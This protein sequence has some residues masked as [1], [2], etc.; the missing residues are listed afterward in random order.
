MT[1]AS[2]T[3]THQISSTPAALK[4]SK[5]C[6]YPGTCFAEQVGVKAPGSANSAM[7]FP[8]AALVVSTGLGP[9]LQPSPSTS[10]YS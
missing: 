10:E 8:A 9:M 4:S 6:T 5:C 7:V 3:L 2:L 1:K